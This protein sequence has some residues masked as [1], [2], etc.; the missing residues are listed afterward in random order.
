MPRS[1]L[2]ENERYVICHMSLGGF[3]PAVIARKLGRHRATIGRELKRNR[4]PYERRYFY[5]T[6]QR[7]A[8][9]RCH[10]THQ[11]YKLDHSPL[12]QIVRK[13]LAQRWS[14]EQIVGRLQRKYPHHR[15][16]RVTHET[17]Y[18]WIYRRHTF[19]ERWYKQ[20]RRRRPRRR[21]RIPGERRRGQIIGRVGIEHRPAIVDRRG[22]FGDWESDT[23]EGAK[24]TGLLATHVERKSRYTRIRKMSDK[25]AAT[26]NRASHRALAD[27]PQC[28]RRTMT[29]DN[30][31]EFAG[32]ASLEQKLNLTVYF[33]NPH[34]PW[35]RG[36]NENTNGLL[37]DFFPKGSDF[38]KV[39]A[40]KVAKAQRMLNNRP[41]KCL[42]YRTP[43]EV[44]NALPGVALRN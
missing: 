42:N 26:L 15:T 7:L 29:A 23:I 16:M 22:R 12:G 30:G 13:E 1:H 19:G 6:A 40:A 10:E 32:F 20:L 44:L 24:S 41:R 3:K 36:V 43:L 9:Q 21:R 11:H 38:R 33:A 31:K 17:I 25:Q 8:E 34:A 18:R 5:D 35:E 27:L 14:P 39:T 2:T 37:R 28:L 4:T